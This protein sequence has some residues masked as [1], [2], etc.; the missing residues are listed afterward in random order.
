M[1]DSLGRG[2]MPVRF[3]AP[4]VQTSEEDWGTLIVLSADETLEAERYLMIQRKPSF[5]EEDRKFGM[6]D[7]YIETCGQGWSWYG[8]IDSF[9]LFP[10]RVIVQ[11]D[12]TAAAEMRDTGLIE[13]SFALPPEQLAA[14]RE[15]LQRAFEGRAYYTDVSNRGHR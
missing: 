15:A 5:S 1:R 8:H 14:L 12:A 3:H 11:L 13:V 10:N 2:T 6:N 9:R 4:F 7:V